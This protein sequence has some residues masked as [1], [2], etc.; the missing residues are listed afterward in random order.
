MGPHDENGNASLLEVRGLEKSFTSGGFLSGSKGTVRAVVDIS[1]SVPRGGVVGLVGESGSGKTT[2]GHCIL[3]LLRPS[4]GEVVFDGTDIV[5]L[6]HRELRPFR[7]RIQMVFQDP[8]SSLNPRVRV[9][10]SIA[11][12]LEIHRI[13]SSRRERQ[14]MVA[15]L[16]NR[17]GLRPDH[18]RRYPHE[19]SG[20][21][22]QRIG[23]ARALAVQPELLIADEPVSALDVSV[24]AQVIELLQNLREAL[25][26][27]MVMIAH[28]LAVVRYVSDHVVVMYLGRIME[29]GPT[30]ELF[31]RP[32]HPYTRALLAAAPSLSQTGRSRRTLLRG[33]LPSPVNPPSGCVFRTRCPIAI[34]RC[35]EAVPPLVETSPGRRVAC[36]VETSSQPA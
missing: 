20:G 6:Q 24:Q 10:D 7:R 15:D 4:G 21:Q 27:T 33:E 8:F 5:P 22:R 11:E 13:G 25:G 17:V 30:D 36:I 34:P 12:P 28:D 26:L 9:G 2:V 1:F 3:R 31:S 29:S 35:A 18:Q 14:E 32:V 19:F 23:I 16:L